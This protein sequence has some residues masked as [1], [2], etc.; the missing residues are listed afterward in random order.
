M[1]NAPEIK[2][3][4][5]WKGACDGGEGALGH[6][7]VWLTIPRESGEICCPYC[8]KKFIIDRANAVEEH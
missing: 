6:P 1:S 3:V 8:G 4:T 2:V 5:H 7:K